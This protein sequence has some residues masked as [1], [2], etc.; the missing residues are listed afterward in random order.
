MENETGAFTDPRD[1]KVYKTI[2]IGNQ[3]WM[4][5]NMNFAVKKVKKLKIFGISLPIKSTN[6][7]SSFI[8]NNDPKF[9]DKYG[10]LYNWEDAKRVAKGLK[11]WHLPS[12]DD[13]STLL[14]SLDR[15]KNQ[16]VSLKEIGFN[17]LFGGWHSGHGALGGTSYSE[18]K[19]ANF[20]SSTLSGPTKYSD[21][22]AFHTVNTAF[23]LYCFEN[24]ASLLCN[25]R[26]YAY[27][28][29]LVRDF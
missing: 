8:Y 4:A 1:G 19:N 3:T 11:G 28:V 22:I 5:E 26:N 15:H 9:A 18:G 13:F 2:T 20:W 29:R 17:V 12:Y 23:Y 16:M 25:I 27:S 21:D 10:R 24:T 7:E 6:E 14:K